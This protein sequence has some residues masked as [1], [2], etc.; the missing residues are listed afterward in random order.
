[1]CDVPRTA[2]FCSEPIECFP[3]ISYKFFLKPFVTIPVGSVIT[4]IIVHFRF[5]III[6]I[7]I[8]KSKV[9][10]VCVCAHVRVCVRVC[11]CVFFFFLD[12]L[13]LRL[14]FLPVLRFFPDIIIPSVLHIHSSVT[15]AINSCN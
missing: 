15:Y 11:I 13:V 8:I 5:H 1:M 12:R 3:G 14:V 7:I 6:I 2:V 9:L 10:C 4:G